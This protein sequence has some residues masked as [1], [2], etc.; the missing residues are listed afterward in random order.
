MPRERNRDS[1]GKRVPADKGN[2]WLTLGQAAAFLGAAQSTVRKW[3]DGGQ[4]PAFYTPGGH[5]RFRRG[6]LEAFLAVPRGGPA[7]RSVLVVDDDDGLREFIRVNLEHD[8]Y[9]VRE[10]RSA[11]EGLRALEEQPPDLILLDVMMPRVDGW[12]MLRAVQE[13]HGVEAIPVIM[14]SGKVDEAD[15]AAK[16]GARAFIGKPF[17]PGQLLEATKQLLRS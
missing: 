15:E 3:A 7:P 9:S 10:A 11:E 17:D 14:Y 4:L 12:E 6:D 5:R 13:R 8:G 16:R 2:E 1:A